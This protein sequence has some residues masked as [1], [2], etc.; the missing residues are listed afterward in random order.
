LRLGTRVKRFGGTHID[1]VQDHS[2]LHPVYV[3]L[4]SFFIV[5]VEYDV[6]EAGQQRIVDHG[7]E[8][9]LQTMNVQSDVLGKQPVDEL[10]LN[11]RAF[12]KALRFLVGIEG[13]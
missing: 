6:E 7:G 12:I 9:I 13:W 11:I 3:V 10:S 8:L 1:E 4:V 2:A 5:L